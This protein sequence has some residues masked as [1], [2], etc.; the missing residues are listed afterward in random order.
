MTTPTTPERTLQG[1]PCSSCSAPMA[2]FGFRAKTGQDMALD[3]CIA[4][5]S[6]WFDKHE[7]QQL[8]ATETLDL[9]RMIHSTGPSQGQPWSAKLKCP[10]CAVDLAP[11]TD[12][13]KS[14]R[15]S[16]FHC[17][18]QHGRFTAFSAFLIE[19]GFVRQLSGEER[20]TLA[21][22]IG[23]VTCSGCG[24]AVDIT[25]D[26]V[27]NF[28]HSPVV[29]LDPHALEDAIQSL[30]TSAVHQHTVDKVAVVDALLMSE[31]QKWL[32]DLHSTSATQGA[33]RNAEDGPL[34]QGVDLL[35]HLF[36][37]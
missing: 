14:G 17:V 27:C 15:F 32:D 5:Q 10:R 7:S 9:F 19:K 23:S 22:R 2:V 30:Q 34:A 20:K 13:C 8:G 26:A 25:K 29:V 18:H 37:R 1:L 12:L 28:C 36:H 4:C 24:A 16:Y 3:V 31:R 11:T 21:A 6:I 35:W 33:W